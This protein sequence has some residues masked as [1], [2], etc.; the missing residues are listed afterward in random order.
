MDERKMLS[1]VVEKHVDDGI[2]YIDPIV[3]S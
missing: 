2:G 3:D 1:R